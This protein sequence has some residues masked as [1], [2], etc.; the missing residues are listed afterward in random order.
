MEEGHSYPSGVGQKVWADRFDIALAGVGQRAQDLE[1]LV[2]SPVRRQRG[3][4]QVNN[5]R[6]R[7]LAIVVLKI[8]C[9]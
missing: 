2:G 9:Q 6:G 3:Q 5:F 1:V 4:W 8:R 7:H